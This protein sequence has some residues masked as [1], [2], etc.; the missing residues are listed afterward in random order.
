MKIQLYCL[1]MKQSLYEDTAILSC[2]VFDFF[3]MATGH[4]VKLVS[5][6]KSVNP[7]SNFSSHPLFSTTIVLI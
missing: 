6:L 1:S 2:I 3:E 7:L 4:G 5:I